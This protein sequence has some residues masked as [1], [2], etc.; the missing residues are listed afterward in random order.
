MFLNMIYTQNQPQKWPYIIKPDSKK[1]APLKRTFPSQSKKPRHMQ[2]CMPIYRL[3]EGL[4]FTSDSQVPP[5]IWQDTFQWVGTAKSYLLYYVYSTSDFFACL[6]T[7]LAPKK[8]WYL[9]DI[10][11]D[12]TRLVITVHY[13]IALIQTENSKCTWQDVVIHTCYMHVRLCRSEEV[14]SMI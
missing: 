9:M 13:K 5:V 6:K 8:V 14:I 11:K 1:F 4:L 3:K 7:L 2:L 12:I 10:F